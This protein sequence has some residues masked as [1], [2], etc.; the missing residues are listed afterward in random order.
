MTRKAA[1]RR[2][3][4]I[5]MKTY[6]IKRLMVV[7]AIACLP[8]ACGTNSPMGPDVAAIEADFTASALRTQPG[9][10]PM[11]TP[12]PESVPVPADDPTTT[13]EPAVPAPAPQPDPGPVPTDPSAPTPDSIPTPNPS[14]PTPGSGGVTPPAPPT[15]QTPTGECQAISVE[16]VTLST[17]AGT[18]GLALEAILL[19]KDGLAITDDSCEKVLWDGS[20]AGTDSVTISYGA[21]SRYVTV[22]GPA[23]TY[24]IGAITP[25]NLRAALVITLH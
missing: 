19:G 14:V 5:E 20:A 15:P 25:N 2:G 18:D 1:L 8:V 24:R 13:E 12:S 23:G 11:E 16:I 6:E 9:V 4:E 7:T 22:S 10:P 21:S 3:K 17:F